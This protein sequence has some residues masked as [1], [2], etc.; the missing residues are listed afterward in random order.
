MSVKLIILGLLMGEERHPY[1]IQQIMKE[2]YM[3]KYIKFQKGSLYYAVE[4]LEKNGFIEVADIK[5]ESNRPEKTIY[6]IT[7]S[8]KEELQNC[9]LEQLS[10][11]EH[12]YHPI[13]AALAFAKYA[14]QAEV[15]AL[16]KRRIEKVENEISIM[17]IFYQEHISFV[18]RAT[19][20]IIVSYIERSKLELKWLIK[21]RN[22][23]LDGKLG[24]VGSPIIFENNEQ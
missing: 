8:G 23:A 12:F 10:A 3:D 5:K 1:E 22:D 24:E 9:L 6:R 13:Y 16:L 15:A 17:N 20:Y 11:F 18:S 19:L 4:Q 14:D 21:L 2:R 7:T